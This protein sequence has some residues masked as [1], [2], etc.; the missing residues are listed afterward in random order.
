MEIRYI[1]VPN[2]NRDQMLQDNVKTIFAQ[3]SSPLG[4][5][6]FRN[7]LKR[8]QKSE[9]FILHSLD[10]LLKDGEDPVIVALAFNAKPYPILDNKV[11]RSIEEL[12]KKTGT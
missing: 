1:C 10:E 12:R 8:M 9:G 11:Y 2:E 4:L 6:V 3:H 5:D 7:E